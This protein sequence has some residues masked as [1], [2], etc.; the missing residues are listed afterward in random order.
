MH[1]M[2][3]PSP[4]W[5]MRS[6]RRS[7]QCERP[8]FPVGRPQRPPF[9]AQRRWSGSKATEWQMV[10]QKRLVPA[11]AAQAREVCVSR[12]GVRNGSQRHSWTRLVFSEEMER[13]GTPRAPNHLANAGTRSQRSGLSGR[14]DGERRGG[15][16][17]PV[18]TWSLKICVLALFVAKRQGAAPRRKGEGEP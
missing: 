13:D 2:E 10:P 9:Q 1:A 12:S 8:A 4:L 14:G 3:E 15:S 7:Q 17:A 11:V 18:F 5:R 16:M 6:Q